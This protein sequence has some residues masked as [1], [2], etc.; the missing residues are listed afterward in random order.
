MHIEADVVGGGVEGGDG[1][2]GV[3]LRG[4]GGDVEIGADGEAGDEHVAG[5]QEVVLDAL[6]LKLGV[7]QGADALRVADADFLA[8]GGQV[9]VEAVL[10]GEIA[11]EAELAAAA[12]GGERLDFEAVLVEFERS[13]QLAEA[14]G[15]VF[16]GERGVLEVDAALEAGIQQRA[17]GLEL[18][19]G[20]A[21]GGQVGVDG[22]GDFEID[23]SAGGKVQL[24]LVLEREAALGVQVGLVA[25]DMQW[26]EMDDGHGR[27][28]HGRRL[29]FAEERRRR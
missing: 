3:G 1:F 10:V 17:V 18:E 19:G 8:G 5:E 16:K 29:R 20:V 22:L 14:V 6:Q 23:G 4:Q 15:H 27:A 12:H 26:V 11:A 25:G 28:W 7:G 2:D 21:A 24:V 13:V 9:G